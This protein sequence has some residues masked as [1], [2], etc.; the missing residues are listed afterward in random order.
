MFVVSIVVWLIVDVTVYVF[1]LCLRCELYCAYM[2]II[3]S[4]IRMLGCKRMHV[5]ARIQYV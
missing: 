4:M 3:H 5:T 1:E 2:H